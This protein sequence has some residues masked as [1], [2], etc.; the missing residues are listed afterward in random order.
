MTIRRADRDQ[1]APVRLPVTGTGGEVPAL[2][3]TPD[4]PGGVPASGPPLVLI[5]HGGGM[6]KESPFV[7]RLA[8]HLVRRL[9]YAALAID[10]PLHGERTPPAERG[11]SPRQRRA[12]L[13]LDAWR[14][15]NAAGTAQAVADWQAALAAA[16]AASLAVDGTARFAPVGYLGLSMGTRFGIPLVA[17][18]PRVTAAVLGLYGHPASDP[19][20]DFAQ[21]A[22][23]VTV[24]LLFLQQW[25]DEL[26]PRADGLN[27]FDLLGSPAK[28]LHANP[29]GHLDVPR[30]EL[31]AAVRFLAG[32]LGGPGTAVS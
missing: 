13:G 27:L 16:D 19:G 18:E 6:R 26:F 10:L 20:A 28:T 11:L 3:W 17:A 7:T 8:G 1:P 12:R 5:G 23:R 32:Q 9:G 24:P 31:D 25:D 15:R 14:E 21:A 29:G 4:P 22:A 30:A 2:L